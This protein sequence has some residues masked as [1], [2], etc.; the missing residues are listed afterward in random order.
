MLRSRFALTIGLLLAGCSTAPSSVSAAPAGIVVITVAG[1]AIESN[2]GQLPTTLDLRISAARALTTSDVSATLDATSLKVAVAADGAA[3]VSSPAQALGSHHHLRISVAGITAFDDSVA[4][5]GVTQVMAAVHGEAGATVVDIAFDNP[6]DQAAVAAAIGSANPAQTQWADAMHVRLTWP[7]NPPVAL[8][9]AATLAVTRGSR[10]AGPA[11]LVLS[12]APQAGTLRRVTV[13]AALRSPPGEVVGFTVGTAASRGA[14]T[15]HA[16]Q[17]SVL[18]PDGWHV[19]SDGQLSGGPD[20]AAV[21]AARHGQVRLLPLLQNDATDATA[22]AALLESS[23]ARHTLV[24]QVSAAVSSSGFAGVNLD[25]EGIAAP[26]RDAFTALATDLAAALH[27]RG[28]QLYVDVVPHKPDHL[29]AYSAGYDVVALAGVADR[30]VLM[31]YDQHT[32]ST[33]AGPV[34][35]LDWDGQ[36]LDGTLPGIYAHHVLLGLPLYARTWQN[37][38]AE[39]GGYGPS[40]SAALLTPGAVV[41]YDFAAATPLIRFTPSNGLGP[42]TCYFDDADSLARKLL[43]AQQRGLAGVALWRLGFEDP[44]AWSAL[45]KPN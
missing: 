28:T 15:D 44:T 2:S 24:T 12:P 29:N 25:I 36:I 14:A 4:I 40:L 19:Q 7:Q 11:D 1:S 23:T 43:L 34:A 10:L 22:T 17:T 9:I 21:A 13:P 42:A 30:V 5:V 6:P 3:N 41:D 8:H 37:G 26:D 27:A 18:A 38:D 33:A 45:A 20:R 39:A 32:A 31:A 16:A 35:G